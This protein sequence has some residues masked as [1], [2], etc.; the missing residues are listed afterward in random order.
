MVR[1]PKLCSEDCT[2]GEIRELFAGDHVHA[3][4]VVSGT[5]LVN[6]ID[7]ADLGP[8]TAES[9][10]AASLGRL[11]GRV[12][13]PT[14]PADAA[15]RQM[16]ADGRRRLAVAGPDRRLLGLLCLK[17]SG[18]GF[19]SDENVR[20]RE[21]GRQPGETAPVPKDEEV[22]SISRSFGAGADAGLPV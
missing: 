10:A 4:L 16:I 1:H 15:L 2:A 22:D 21:A 8:G 20:Q 6:V 14:A 7:R 5:R 12:I 19:C 17:R 18:T 11:H 3:V 9:A 13:A